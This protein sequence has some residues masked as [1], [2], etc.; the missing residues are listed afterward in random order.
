MTTKQ[1]HKNPSIQREI[2]R[3]LAAGMQLTTVKELTR[4]VKE[5]GYRFDRD[6]DTRSTSRI[7]SGPGAGDSYPNCYL[8][9]VQDDDGLSAYHYQARRDANYEKLK[10]IRNDF[11]AVTNNHVVVF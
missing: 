1:T 6:L 11:F 4:M 5:V 3:N 10:T 9:V 2:V 7:M 8:Y